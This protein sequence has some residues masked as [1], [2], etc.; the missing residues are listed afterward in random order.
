MTKFG[1]G[2]GGGK[3]NGGGDKNVNPEITKIMPLTPEDIAF[4][5]M[6]RSMGIDVRDALKDPKSSNDENTR[7]DLPSNEVEISKPESNVVT[8]SP[9]APEDNVLEFTNYKRE[10]GVLKKIMT[11]LFAASLSTQFPNKANAPEISGVKTFKTEIYEDTVKPEK[12]VEKLAPT[13]Q[14]EIEL[15]KKPEILK[16]PGKVALASEKAL[17]DLEPGLIAEYFQIEHFKILS[18][19]QIK[20]LKKRYLT[21]IDAGKF[22]DSGFELARM[23][24]I[25]PGSGDENKYIWG[26]KDFAIKFFHIVGAPNVKD[27]KVKL[28]VE[29]SLNVPT[30][31]GRVD[32]KKS[33]FPYLMLFPRNRKKLNGEEKEE[34]FPNE[35]S[36]QKF[37]EEFEMIVK[38]WIR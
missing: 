4:G 36:R 13:L 1:E 24:A 21:L 22:V 20:A 35:V 6:L 18:I 14:G 16:D 17:E 7:K 19:S 32:D 29:D 9:K 8:Q 11:L 25:L 12:K 38:D 5:E 2:K 23:K 15:L 30:I 31:Y 27:L 28:G 37:M 26:S 3:E 33:D 34:F 10:N